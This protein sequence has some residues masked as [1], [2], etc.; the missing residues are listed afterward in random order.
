[1]KTLPFT[2]PPS[3]GKP[4]WKKALAALLRMFAWT[5]DFALALFVVAWVVWDEWVLHRLFGCGTGAWLDY[6]A[7]WM[8]SIYKHCKQQNVAEWKADV[9][10]CLP[11]LLEYSIL[12][13]LSA[14][15]VH[16]GRRLL[17]TTPGEWT[18]SVRR[19]PLPPPAGGLWRRLL[20]AAAGIAALLAVL[21]L[22][23]LLDLQV[24]DPV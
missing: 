11:D 12:W 14:L 6:H 1:M 8:E 4:V 2:K 15:L 3:D 21:V 5:Y 19:P 13:I 18:F 20:R 16:W 7:A 23:A 17:G 10:S 22:W 24:L 9:L